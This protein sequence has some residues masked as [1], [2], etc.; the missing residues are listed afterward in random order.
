MNKSRTRVRGFAPW[1]PS[2]KSQALLEIVHTILVEYVNYLPLTV[3]QI[4]YRLVGAYDYPKTERAYKNLGEKLNRARRA[5]LV[6]WA[7]I[8]DDGI[9]KR[10]PHCW[11]DA[12]ECFKLA[13]QLGRNLEPPDVGRRSNTAHTHRQNIY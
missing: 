12:A 2:G 5:G 6:D 7:A 13:R 3:R 10:V 9:I 8:R 4:F 1:R 11:Q